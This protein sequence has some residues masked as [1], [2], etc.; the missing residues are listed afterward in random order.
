L[1]TAHHRDDQIET[2]LIRRRAGSGPDGLAGM[3]AIRELADCRLLRPLLGVPR[4][5][6][7]AFLETEAQPFITDPSNC[8]PR[9]ERAR[10]R[11]EGGAP[12]NATGASRVLAEIRSF[13]EMRAA[14]ERE[15]SAVLARYVGLHPAGFGLLDPAMLL[16]A[17]PET[18]DR[19]LSRITAAIGGAAYPPR[20]ERIARLREVLGSAAQRG[21]TLGGC[22]FRRWRERFLVTRELAKAAPPLGVAPGETIIWDR[23]FEVVSPRRAK[24]I[25]T[26][27]YLGAAGSVRRDLSVVELRC[28]ALPRLLFP[29]LPA[30]WD[31]EGIAAIPHLGYRREGIVGVLEAVF[32]PVNVL[33]EAGFAVV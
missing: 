18:V 24:G 23:R 10:L 2:Y 4:D 21:H 16:E 13:G 14:R 26:I 32:R 6:L 27:G 31:E 11:R 12:R 5:R 9:F 17:P 22:R 20:R 1:L 19:V 7:I 30:M 8:D 29:V 33:T 25:F 3:S 28:A 15:V